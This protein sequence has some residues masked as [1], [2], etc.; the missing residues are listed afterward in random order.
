[1]IIWGGTL[2][3]QQEAFYLGVGRVDNETFLDVEVPGCRLVT[4]QPSQHANLTQE[5]FLFNSSK[6]LY[7]T[8]FTLIHSFPKVA[9]SETELTFLYSHPGLTSA[10]QSR[11]TPSPSPATFNQSLN[12]I[13]YAFYRH[14]W[15]ILLYF[16]THPVFARSFIIIHL[17]YHSCLPSDLLTPSLSPL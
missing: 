9:M 5:L 1:M 15:S 8:V 4:T 7:L 14:F 2:G 6:L 11:N 13:G 17:N 3:S 10:M 16:I 12:S